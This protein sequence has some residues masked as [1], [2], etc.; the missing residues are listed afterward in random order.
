MNST[1]T[2]PE[3]N[4]FASIPEVLAAIARGEMVVIVDDE[5]REN[6]GDFIMAAEHATPEKLAF[7]VRYSTGVICAPLTRERAEELRLPLM[8]EQN[9]ESQRTAYTI[10]VDLIAE[11]AMNK[12]LRF[13]IRDGGRPVGAG[14]VTEIIA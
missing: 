9:T 3:D 8:V 4:G 13:A 2:Q 12:G 5:D 7:I 14:Q 6:E 1:S 11:I 10:T